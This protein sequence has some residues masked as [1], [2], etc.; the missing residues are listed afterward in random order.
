M[1]LKDTAEEA[2]GNTKAL[3]TSTEC[4]VLLQTGVTIG[5]NMVSTLLSSTGIVLLSVNLVALFLSECS[6]LRECS[7]IKTFVSVS[8]ILLDGLF[9]CDACFQF[10]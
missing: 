10:Y 1:G 3:S 7:L 9:T 6:E 2:S 8:T 4:I 5:A